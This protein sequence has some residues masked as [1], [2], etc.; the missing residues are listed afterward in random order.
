MT[1]LHLS[2]ETQP[3]SKEDDERMSRLRTFP[4]RGYA[5]SQI[6]EYKCVV[7]PPNGSPQMLTQTL[8]NNGVKKEN[9]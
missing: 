2:R 1:F 5:L 9:Q 3:C 7:S 4:K 6:E 8:E